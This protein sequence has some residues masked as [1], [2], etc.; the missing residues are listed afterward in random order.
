M[1]P[2]FEFFLHLRNDCM[3]VLLHSQMDLG[4]GLK[5]VAVALSDSPPCPVPVV[6]WVL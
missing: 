3:E 6:I 2:F 5:L 4:M 1:R